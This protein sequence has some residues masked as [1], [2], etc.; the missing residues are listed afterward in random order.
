[1]P[2]MTLFD[3]SP[4]GAAAPPTEMLE[5]WPPGNGSDR[6]GEPRLRGGRRL[7]GAP[8]RSSPAYQDS[9]PR[10]PDVEVRVERAPQEDVGGALG[11]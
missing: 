3:V 10:V 1:M 2:F 6:S 11:G 8:D 4:F 5:D 9:A 7:D